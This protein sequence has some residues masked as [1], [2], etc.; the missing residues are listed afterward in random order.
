[1]AGRRDGRDDRGRGR[2]DFDRRNNQ[3]KRHDKGWVPRREQSDKARLVAYDVLRMV[4][5]DDA[6]A[7]LVLPRE[8]RR[9][10][11]NK[12][13]AAYATNLCYGTLR[14]RG[15]WDAIISRCTQGRTLED[16]DPELLDILRLGC[17]QLLGFN[18]PVHAAINETVKL[19]RNE[20]G[21]GAGGFVNAILR[22]VSERTDD[23]EDVIR[24]STASETEFLSVWYS[25]PRW[26]VE[27]LAESLQANGRSADEL[28]QL[29]EADNAPAKVALVARGISAETLREKIEAAHMESSES[30]LMPNAVLLDSGDPHRLWAVQD[31]EAGVQ[32]EGSQ[33]IAAVT[34]GAPI[35]GSDELWLDMCAGPGGKTATLAAIATERGARI[36]A[37]EPQPHRLDLVADA[38]EPWADI[39]GLRE[40]DGRELGTEEAEQYDRVLVDAPCTGLGALR[41]RPEARWRKKASD[42][43]DLTKLQSELL[44]AGFDALREG[45]V[46]VYSTCSPVVAET[47]DI[48]TRFLESRPQA[49]LVDAAPI[50]TSQAK[51]EVTSVGRMIQLWPDRDDTDAMFIAVIQKKTKG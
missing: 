39:V 44:A 31:G 14:L 42:V 45:G 38:V 51:R 41:R 20:L 8:I 26:V 30:A 18:T 2:R 27:A 7:N 29:L 37:N 19:A 6:Y 33:L 15:R 21:Q 28:A 17:Q 34:A 32:D 4:A 47:R 16:I 36:H 24:A 46:L 48:V 3:G 40:G 1:M 9:A 10:R 43:E 35:A 25:H 23:W 50:A 22:R 12:L 13:D 49:E 11:L 5:D